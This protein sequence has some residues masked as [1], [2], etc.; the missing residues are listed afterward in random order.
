MHKHRCAQKL[1]GSCNIDLLKLSSCFL[2][3]LLDLNLFLPTVIVHVPLVLMTKLLHLLA[4]DSFLNITYF[5]LLVFSLVMCEQL[6]SVCICCK[7]EVSSMA[8]MCIK[9]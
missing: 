6:L 9:Y 5:K 2:L 4:A 1:A 8:H 3:K 7:V